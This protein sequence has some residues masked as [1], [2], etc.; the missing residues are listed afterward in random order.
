[1]G[2]G[3]PSSAWTLLDVRVISQPTDVNPVGFDSALKACTTNPCRNVIPLGAPGAYVAEFRA[4]PASDT[5]AIPPST[6]V[7]NLLLDAQLTKTWSNSVLTWPTNFPS[8]NNNVLIA[9]NTGSGEWTQGRFKL[10]QTLKD[11]SG[12]IVS[13][14]S[15]DL[16]QA[17]VSSAAD[18]TFRFDIVGRPALPGQ[19]VTYEFQMSRDN[20]PFGSKVNYPWFI[21]P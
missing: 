19:T 16:P 3:I 18:V 15:L 1:M 20:V 11:Q 21:A 2:G 12:T 7:P 10:L 17:S 13:T 14:Q 6:L 4:R 5:S 8:M 9:K